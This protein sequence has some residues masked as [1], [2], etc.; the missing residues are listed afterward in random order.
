[1]ESVSCGQ[2]L[3]KRILIRAVALGE[4]HQA[5][6]ELRE[7]PARA[8]C[9]APSADSDGRSGIASPSKGRADQQYAKQG[10]SR[11]APQTGH[12]ERKAVDDQNQEHGGEQRRRRDDRAAGQQGAEPQAL[13][14]VRRMLGSLPAVGRRSL[15]WAPLSEWPGI[16]SR[17]RIL[18]MRRP[19]PSP[20]RTTTGAVA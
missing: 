15:K 20:E 14:Q 4:C 18:P 1:M 17:A 13:L 9:A 10:G 7:R 3:Q 8:R 11:R 5:L 19:A 6:F 16:D 2:K 12:R